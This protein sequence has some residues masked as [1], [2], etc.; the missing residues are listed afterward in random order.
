MQTSISIVNA[1]TCLATFSISSTDLLLTCP[2][3]ANLS[4]LPIDNYGLANLERITSLRI[5][6]FNGARGP[7]QT[8]P[9]NICFLTSLQVCVCF[10]S[11]FFLINSLF[12]SKVLNISYNRLDH[13]DTSFLSADP[14]CLVTLRTLDMSNNY[15]TEFPSLFLTKTTNLRRLFL[16]NNQLT[17]FDLALFVLVSTS[18]DLSNNQISKI[19][20]DAN[21]NI[22]NYTYSLP[23]FINLTNNS[24]IIDLTDA[25]YE[26]Y[27]ACYEIDQIFN[28]NIPSA[29]SL[30]TIDF[31]NINFG[32]SKVNCTCNQY[33]LQKSFIYSIGVSL[34]PT[35]PLSTALCSDGRLF[36][37]NNLTAACSTSSVNFT[38]TR[39]RLCKLNTND[40]N[41]I[42]VNRTENTTW[43]SSTQQN[44]VFI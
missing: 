34:S 19:T 20:N 8:I 38:N 7:L 12:L 31:L 4:L 32:T 42:F 2:S 9:P 3:S 29:A 43:V 17:S 1:S 44:R 35:Y 10:S 36:Y 21:V 40:G 18:I 16:H 14:F 26:M 23:A 25:I 28:S 37:N 27:G 5:E 24:P 22:S 41:L 6:G 39:P 30:L 13:L 11:S 33:Y 15:F